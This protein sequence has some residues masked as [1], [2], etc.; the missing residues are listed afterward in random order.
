MT[1]VLRHS[2]VRGRLRRRLPFSGDALSRIA[3]VTLALLVLVGIVGR[4]FHLGGDP[5][6]FVGPRQGGPTGSWWFGTDN[7]GRSV[8]ARTIDGIGTT[9]VLA[10]SAVLIASVIG[11]CLGVVAALRGGLVDQLLTRAVDV[12]L[13]FP[14]ILLAIVVSAIIGPGLGAPIVAIV[15]AS[16]PLLFRVVRA[17]AA[18]LVTRDFVLCARVGGARVPR[19]LFVHLV[20]NVAGAAVVQATYALSMGILI[21]SALSF[22]GL[23]VREPASSLGSLLQENSLYLPIN[24]WPT[25]GPGIVLALAVLSINLVGDGLR[26]ALEPRQIRSLT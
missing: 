14:S 16:V 22:L 25:I 5:T 8:F 6:A 3:A 19:V 26:D 1:S 12:L 7:L 15:I 20:P 23:G 13:S 9:I 18:E 21:E 2:P 11:T 10:G 24:P 17:S 4:L